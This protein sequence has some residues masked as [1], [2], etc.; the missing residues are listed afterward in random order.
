[1]RLWTLLAALIPLL[2]PAER[3]AMRDLANATDFECAALRAYDQLCWSTNGVEVCAESVAIIDDG[4]IG[5]RSLAADVPCFDEATPSLML[6][7]A[8]N[9]GTLR[10]M[11]GA[12]RA[13]QPIV[14]CWLTPDNVVEY[15]PDEDAPGLFVLSVSAASGYLACQIDGGIIDWIKVD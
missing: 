11:L 4:P 6:T 12:D 2:A 1:M 7:F 9:A 8:P 14:T 5:N 3:Y 15:V 10:M 13:V